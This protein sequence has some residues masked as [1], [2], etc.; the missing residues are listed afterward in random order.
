MPLRDD[1]G[2][3]AAV[4]AFL[5]D[6]TAAW[7]ERQELWRALAALQRSASRRNEGD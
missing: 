5:R 7:Q 6:V 3:V 1:A 2:A 4:A